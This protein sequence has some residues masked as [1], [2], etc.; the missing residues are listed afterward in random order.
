MGIFDSLFRNSGDDAARL[1]KKIG[2][3]ALG[4]AAKG[5]G[6]VFT[7]HE[8]QQHINQSQPSR[9]NSSGQHPHA[10]SSPFPVQGEP[11]LWVNCSDGFR[12]RVQ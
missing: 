7:A 4:G 9:Q 1:A 8:L 3:E 2:A 6:F 5:A 11:G 10:I 12:R